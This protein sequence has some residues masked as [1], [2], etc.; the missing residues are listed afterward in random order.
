VLFL[1]V[2]VT[3]PDS[4]VDISETFNFVAF[5]FFCASRWTF[6]RLGAI[7]TKQGNVALE[8]DSIEA[9]MGGENDAGDLLTMHKLKN[10]DAA[11][12]FP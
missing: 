4:A 10:I 11:R 2:L 9:P 6:Q 8:H 3:S 1:V 12:S 7:F 5:I